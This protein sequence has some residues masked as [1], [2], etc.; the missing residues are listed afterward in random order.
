M[1]NYPGIYDPQTVTQRGTRV[2]QNKNHIHG[3]EDNNIVII[4]IISLLLLL[5]ILYIF[6]C[7]HILKTK[8]TVVWRPDSR[9]RVSSSI[10]IGTKFIQSDRFT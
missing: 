5:F 9:R 6:C 7:T 1:C 4:I 8:I 2:R 10:C 3:R